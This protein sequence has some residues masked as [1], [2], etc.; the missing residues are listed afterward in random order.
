VDP[1]AGD[2][3]LP[4]VNVW[5]EDVTWQRD[6]NSLRVAFAY[7][8]DVAYPYLDRSQQQVLEIDLTLDVTRPDWGAK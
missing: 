3:R 7:V 1:D 6:G 4:A 5:P 8:R 2:E